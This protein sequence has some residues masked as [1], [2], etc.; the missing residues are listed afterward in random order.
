MLPLIMEHEFV[1]LYSYQL[2]PHMMYELS[3]IYSS[4]S[5]HGTSYD[6]ELTC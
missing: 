4:R 2:L 3:V 6:R 5:K 1:A